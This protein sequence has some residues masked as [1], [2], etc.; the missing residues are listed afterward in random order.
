M[1]LAPLLVLTAVAAIVG[2][3]VLLLRWRER[4]R[5]AYGPQGVG[6]ALARGRSK[7]R[8]HSDEP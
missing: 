8:R 4:G 3:V 6:D 7:F 1:S 2:V 5:R